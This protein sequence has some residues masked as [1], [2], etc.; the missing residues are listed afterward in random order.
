MLHLFLADI[1]NISLLEVQ[2][3]IRKSDCLLLSIAGVTTVLIVLDIVNSSKMLKNS[4]LGYDP[5]IGARYYGIGNEYMGI[6]AGSTV[7]ALCSLIER[8]KPPLWA[9]VL[10][11]G[12]VVIAVGCPAFGANLGGAISCFVTF[13]FFLLRL[14]GIKTGIKQ[15]LAVGLTLAE[16]LVVFLLVDILLI[17]DCTHLAAAAQ[18]ALKTGPSS[19]IPILQRKAAMNAKLFRFNI[20]T[21]ML[22]TVI[23]VT[24]VL[25]YRPVGIFKRIFI[26]YPVYTMGWSSLTVAATVGMAV[27]D[28]GIVASAT[29]SIFFITSI[30]YIVIQERKDKEKCC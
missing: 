5:I 12:A 25:F 1:L 19:L 23:T 16:V 6:V 17:D 3:K 13:S 27:N 29:C 4:V 22:I 21:K 2:G 14:F 8:Y 18:G 10:I 30:L 20:W 11:F 9:V 15:L 28:S 7:I 24:G 26:K